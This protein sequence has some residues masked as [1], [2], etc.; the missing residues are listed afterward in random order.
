MYLITKN[1]VCC[2]NCADE[3]PMQAI[4][5]VGCKYEINQDKCVECGLCAKV[6]HTASIIDPD[7]VNEVSAHGLIVKEADVVVCGGGTGLVAAVRAALTGKKVILLEKSSRLGGNTDYAHGFF[8]VFTKWHEEAGM[9]DRREDA[10][11]HYMRATEGKIDESIFRTAVYAC[12]D[13]FDW[14]CTVA[15]CRS[16]YNLVDLGDADAH[17]PI[18]GPGLLD[19]PNRYRDH[20]NC[21]DDAIGPGW[22]GTFVKYSMLEAIEKLGLNVEILMEHGACKLLTDE[23]GAITGVLANDPGGQTQINA[24]AVILATGGFGK[25]DEKLREFAPWFFEGET[26]IHRF[27]VPTDTGD[28]IDMLRDLGVEPVPERLCISMFGPK[29]HPFNNSLAD[30]ALDPIMLQVNLDGKRWI[31]EGLGMFPMVPLIGQQ[32]KEI[33]WAIQSVD[34]FEIAANSVLSNPVMAKRHWQFET[35]RE[36]LEHEA[37]LDTPVKKADTIEELAQLCGMPVEAL[38][39]TVKNYNEFCAKGE[40]AEFGK[41][42]ALLKPLADHGPY[43]AVYGKRFSEAGMGGLM[44]DGQCRVLRNDGSFIPGLYGV[45]DA[46]S[47]M[48]LR[49]R[50]AVVSELTWGVASAYTSGNNASQYVDELNQ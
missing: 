39:E 30:L 19:F 35:W 8:P 34:N 41:D 37:T 10:I 46:T 15:D 14:L 38:V 25:S 22:Q 49:G 23:K 21:R 48:H 11:K 33:S 1:C 27:S 29:H 43:F 6:C 32:P 3:C 17:G 24:P 42:P 44:V 13:F 9:P 4:D 31:N 40:D 12:G 36:D 18:F 47:A 26:P 45:G 7:A 20:L 2:H 28:G 50:L 16:V 5:F